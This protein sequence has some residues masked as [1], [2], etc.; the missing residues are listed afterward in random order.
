MGKGNDGKRV[1]SDGIVVVKVCVLFIEPYNLLQS[2]RRVKDLVFRVGRLLYHSYYKG[3]ET[4]REPL[5]K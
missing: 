4:W 3:T 2:T 5:L 1:L